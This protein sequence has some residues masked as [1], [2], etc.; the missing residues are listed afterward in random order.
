MN[1]SIR[2]PGA[3]LFSGAVPGTFRAC[4]GCIR[5]QTYCTDWADE[6]ACRYIDIGT[7]SEGL[8]GLGIMAYVSWPWS[9][10]RYTND[11]IV[12]GEIRAASR[13]GSVQ[14]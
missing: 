3:K 1:A 8:G 10:K 12:L 6:M 2:S 11:I 14:S 5:P 7:G 4:M 9:V 13:Y